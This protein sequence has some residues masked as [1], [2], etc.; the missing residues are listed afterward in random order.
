MGRVIV[1]LYFF[2]GAAALLYEVAWFRRLQLVFGV[3]AFA[4]GAVVSGFMLGLAAGS[5]W[6]GSAKFPNARPL[7]AYS[8]QEGTLA[9]YA[10]IFPVLVVVIEQ[11]YSSLFPTL[12]GHFMALS[13][14][15][16]GLSVLV[17]LPPTFCMGATLPTLAR[18]VA[19]TGAV[20]SRSVGSLYAVNTFGAVIGTLAAGFFTLE[21]LGIRGTIWLAAAINALIACT[22][23]LLS[24]RPT[25]VR[26]RSEVQRH[27]RKEEKRKA[28]GDLRLATLV[29]AC[30]GFVSMALEVV[31]TRALVFY[32]HNSTYAFSAILAVYLLGLAAGA[33]VAARL[34]SRE[35]APKWLGWVLLATCL[36][37]LVAIGVYR[38]IPG[39]VR[40]FLGGN[41]A[42]EL[43]SLPDRSFSIVRS[44]STALAVI[45]LEAGAVLFLP[46]F[47]FGLAFPLALRLGEGSAAE[48]QSLVGR[49]Y[50]YNTLG[51]VGGTILA[52]FGLIG[53]LGTRGAIV[54]LA[55]LTVPPG[56]W[57]LHKGAGAGKPRWF[58]IISTS[59][60]LLAATM[61]TAPLGFYRQMFER[62]FGTVLWFSEGAAETV[63]ICRH[64]D[65]AAWIHYSD[66]RGASGTTSFRGGWLYAHVPLL[67]HPDPH[68]ALVICF[69]TGNTLGAASLHHLDRLDCAELSREVVKASPFF[70]DTNHGV[71]QSAGVHII[72]EDGR[73]Y[74][75]GTD[76]KYDVITEEPPM[77]HTASVVNLYTRDFYRLCRAHMTDNG[78]MAVWLATWELE[79]PELKMLVR[80]FVEAFPYASA[81]D[82][83][84]L[85][86][87]IL[88]GSAKPLSVDPDKL[89]PRMSEPILSGDLAKLGIRT[90]AELLGLYMK[91]TAF[92]EQFT[93]GV[94]AVTDDRSIVDYTIPRQARAN[95]GLGDFTTGGINV[96]GVSPAGLVSELRVRGFD[97]IYTHR[98]RPDSLLSGTYAEKAKLFLD[99]VDRSRLGAETE[100]GRKLAWNVEATASDY[101]VLGQSQKSLELLD[102]G[103][104]IVGI[105][106]TSDLLVKKANIYLK[107]GDTEEARKTLVS[108][109]Q[110]DPKNTQALKLAQRLMAN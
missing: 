14:V 97:A 95:F 61:I 79:E 26:V 13:A 9:A 32:V 33:A 71:D 87:W 56:L 43:A 84:H 35:N 64:A 11:I 12:G 85:G 58:L 16:L 39:L 74:L 27:A 92:L 7:L 110:I 17:L 45:F 30:T 62:R 108:A 96:S 18:A 5:R 102:W 8:I 15:R 82:S 60:C 2:S 69:G 89:G 1:A 66:G 99:E 105:V 103:T 52:A 107:D 93:D 77:I 78:I 10:V 80:A 6:A 40:P 101:Q 90:P 70:K 38:H 54:F 34:S 94:Q 75:L 83:K 46:A 59:A 104:N 73:N 65:N 68:S 86:E 57:L 29:V 55:W 47:A 72:I 22:A 106:A 20:A 63:A 41:L 98:E 42:Q 67:L 23:F 19:Q 36:S 44:W 49:L 109:L 53:L 25:N 51:G 91:G 37:T 24:R 81:W 50:A 100:A 76:A 88:I 48:T 4:I 3:S 21:R 31:W 28:H